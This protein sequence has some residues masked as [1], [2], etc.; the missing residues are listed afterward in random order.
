M[1]CPTRSRYRPSGYLK[2]MLLIYFDQAWDKLSVIEW[3]QIYRG[4]MQLAE[5]VGNISAATPFTRRHRRRA[6]GCATASGS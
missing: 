6:S 1:F 4:Q 5:Q 3:Q 2:Y